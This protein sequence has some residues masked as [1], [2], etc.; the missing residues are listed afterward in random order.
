[1]RTKCLQIIAQHF[2]KAFISSYLGQAAFRTSEVRLELQK[3]IVTALFE[4]CF[5]GTFGEIIVT[6]LILKLQIKL[7]FNIKL[8][9]NFKLQVKIRDFLTNELLCLFLN[10]FILCKIY[11]ADIFTTLTKISNCPCPGF[12][13]IILYLHQSIY[14]TFPMKNYDLHSKS[15]SLTVE[16][17]SNL[18]FFPLVSPSFDLGFQ[19]LE[20]YG[21]HS[22]MINS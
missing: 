1:M 12:Y 19:P 21:I 14:S 8:F 15:A 16:E 5:K 22:T 18:F 10:V 4:M 2:D 9:F 3:A 17:T 13:L 11:F 20:I 6:A 7:L